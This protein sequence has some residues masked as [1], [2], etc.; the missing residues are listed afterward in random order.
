MSYAPA[1]R[2]PAP[3][4]K[5]TVPGVAIVAALVWLAV[6]YTGPLGGPDLRGFEEYK[7][8]DRSAIPVALAVAADRSAV[9]FTLESSN[10]IGILRN[11]RLAFVRK[12]FESIEPLGLAIDATGAAWFTEAPKQTIVRASADG[13]ITSFPLATPIARLGRLA[14]SPD[15]TIW[16]AELTRASVTQFK[17]GRFIRHSVAV[18][19]PGIPTDAVP[20]GVAVAPDATVWATLQNVDA[21]LRI[22]PSGEATAIDVPIRQSGLADIAIAKDGAVWFLAA[23]ANKI[24][25]Y[26]G[27]RFEE[28]SV[29]TPNAGL[30]ALAVAPDGAAWFTAL[31]AHRLG[32]VHQG[33][34]T[35]FALPRDNARPIGIA[36]D[37]DNNVWYAD[38]AGWIGKLGADRARVR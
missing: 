16:F 30:T 25:R 36:V 2:V 3:W 33:V 28:F 10:M 38:L 22:T 27:G 26:A 34:V 37:A 19:A 8:P 35:E 9:W 31:R 18:Q 23:G 5:W 15:N 32:R 20:F 29:P 21:L 4:W 11:G 14:V 7:L 17:D 13:S 24:G 6:R 1:A 12:D